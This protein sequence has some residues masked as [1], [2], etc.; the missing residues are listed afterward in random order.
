ME[1]TIDLLKK[2]HVKWLG[3][4]FDEA[5][6]F[7][8]IIKNKVAGIAVESFDGKAAEIALNFSNNRV[9]KYIPDEYKDEIHL[10][11][12]DIING[13]ND[14]T[15]AVTNFIDIIEQLKDKLKMK[16]YIKSITDSLLEMIKAAVLIFLDRNKE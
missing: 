12:D 2:E 5:F 4:E 8:E 11:L 7:K 14:Y 13:D 16:P 15:I 3:N 6:D 10:A 9:S 1:N